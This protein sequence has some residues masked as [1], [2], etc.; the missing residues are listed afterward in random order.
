[1]E[2][3]VSHFSQGMHI[4][5]RVIYNSLFNVPHKSSLKLMLGEIYKLLTYNTCKDA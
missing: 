2:S 5:N 1:M 3:F 4:A